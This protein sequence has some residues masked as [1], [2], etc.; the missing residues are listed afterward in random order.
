[1][2]PN[3]ARGGTND[4]NL[5][6]FGLMNRPFPD[7]ELR[8]YGTVPFPAFQAVGR[9]HDLDHFIAENPSYFQQQVANDLQAALQNNQQFKEDI[10]A[11]YIM[12]NVDLGRFSL[13]TG[14][15]V[16][17]TETKGEGSL[18]IVTPE[19]RARRA[20]WGTAPLTDA[21][22][23]RRTQEEF[24]RRQT[25][26]GDYRSVFPGVHLK[27]LFNR[28]LLARASYST[29]IGR[30]NIGQLIP[31]TTVNLDNQTLSTSNPSLEPQT[32][33][34][35]DISTEYYFEPA[36]MITAGVFMK[37]IRKFIYTAGGNV[38]GSGTDNGFNG[39]YAGYTLTTQYNGGFA[40]VRGLELG[41]MQ[42]FTM[43]PGIWKGL[44]AYANMTRMIA[45]GNYGAGN[46]IALAPN[47]RVAGF[48]PFIANAGVS[49]IRNRLNLRVQYNYRGK[50]LTTFNA[51]ESR[52]VYAHARPT[53]DVKTLY[54]LNR[55]FSVYL[56][57]VNIFTEPDRQIEFG[58][59][60]PQTTHLMRP[61]FFFGV[62]G[63]L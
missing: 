21:E 2:G 40:K 7:T 52:A 34:N 8:R 43:L 4:D 48:N 50:Y 61:Q 25:R 23:R 38:V 16:E 41:Y 27:Y 36:G 54:N 22:I 12:G 46:A 19:E 56:D 39:D 20:A 35:F 13:L 33:K 37:Q 9:P 28:N 44:G 53:V 31:R 55:Q 30:P 29:S 10:S 26:T 15:R 3:A 6:Q 45:E 14:V 24:G 17:K 57:V 63:R 49:Y 60:R 58:Y 47:P 32:A 59:G 42:Q 11:A 62:N 1:M 5:A 18:Q 51:N